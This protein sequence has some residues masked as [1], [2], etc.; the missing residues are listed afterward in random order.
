MF[1]FKATLLA[2][3]LI[4]SGTAQTVQDFFD[5]AQ[6]H[7]IRL[8]METADW[9]RLHANYL[10]KKT[11]YK[12]TF[13]WRGMRVDNVGLHTRGTGSLNPI[14]PGLGIEFA[15]FDKN[16]RFLGLSSVF[17]RNFAED[18]SSLHERIAMQV[19]AAM[20]LP[21]QRT[22]HA[23][24]FVNDT[25]VGL[26]QTLEPLD[27]RFLQTRFGETTGYLYEGIG[28]L[29]YHFE[30]LGSD[31]A[32]YV[33]RY[34][35][36]KNHEDDPQAN[37]IV[38]MVRTINNAPAD[39]FVSDV[40]RF[41]DLDTFVAF[42]A[43]EMALAEADGFLSDSGMSNYYLYRRTGDDRFFF[44]VWDKE[45]AFNSSTYSVWQNASV[46]VLMRRTLEIPEL[47]SRYMETIHQVASLLGGPGGWMASE[48]DREYAQIRQATAEDPNRV[49]TING[50]FARCE[51]AGIEAPIAYLQSFARERSAFL[52]DTLLQSGWIPDYRA[53]YLSP[54]AAG[55]AGSHVAIL[56]PAQLATVRTSLSLQREIHAQEWPF[57]TSLGG[58]SVTLSGTLMPV[59]SVSST[60]IV[61]YV[62]PVTPC[63]PATLSLQVDGLASRSISIEVRP[64]N[65]GVLSVTHASGQAVSAS[66][67]ASPGESLIAWVTGLGR[68]EGSAIS[69][70][71]AGVP[72]MLFGAG[73]VPGSVLQVVVFQVPQ[74]LPVEA[75]SA[76]VVVGVDGEPGG[77][78]AL[79]L[80][81][82][83]T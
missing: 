74:A 29:D 6:L 47:K 36:P 13:E 43:V 42:A 23:R 57:P 55:N 45:M 77:V 65:P 62:P 19:Y 50:E 79:P 66:S 49:C 80:R 2:V 67:P 5:G 81:T 28:E 41:L 7:D 78:F 10:D 22:A 34:F 35:E 17:L 64:A 30:D 44:L 63:G 9:D 53:P 71:V 37:R 12:C 1:Y 3:A 15:K 70:W 82:G 83:G 51:T 46:N 40:S 38:D 52:M 56:A 59:V 48:I 18:P 4:G 24:L 16:Q 20:G 76:A 21:Y 68:H 31:P 72:A 14:K 60:A 25:Y 8:T 33:P 75:N 26:Y 58:V 54:G 39:T 73:S 61:F 11:N 32:S 69:V 27:S